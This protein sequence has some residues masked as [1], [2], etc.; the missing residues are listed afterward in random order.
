MKKKCPGCDGTYLR[1]FWDNES[2]TGPA[3][4]TCVLCSHEVKRVGLRF[5]QRRYVKLQKRLEE[6]NR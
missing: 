3:M 6:L 5:L 4:W 2:L 1:L